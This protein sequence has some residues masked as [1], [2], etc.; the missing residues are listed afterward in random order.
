M[1]YIEIINY[2]KAI[3][4]NIVL[5]NIN[6]SFNKGKIYGLV[7]KNGSGKTMLIR[8]I[9]GL[10]TA[11]KGEISVDGLKV[12][13]GIYPKSIGIVIENINLFDY[14]SAYENLKMLNNISKNKIDNNDI[15][16]W[17]KK[18][19]LDENDKRNIKKYSL[20]M[21]QKVSLIQAFMNKPELIILDEPTN[22]LDEDSIKILTDIIK[23]TNKNEN[24]TFIIASHDKES[25]YNLCDKTV[26]M[27]DGK[28]VQISL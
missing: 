8:A 9:C 27:R 26:E 24:T 25:L 11:D 5:D 22:A 4:K 12:G 20:G 19:N 13:N 15:K 3:N 17:L 7:G 1:A 14:I 18:F 28:V 10:I 6:L 16:M 2:T 21:R 23:E